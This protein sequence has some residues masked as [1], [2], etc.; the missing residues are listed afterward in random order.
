MEQSKKSGQSK[1]FD[2]LMN[3]YCLELGQFFSTWVFFMPNHIKIAPAHYNFLVNVTS[4]I[5]NNK[6]K[7][8][9][10]FIIPKT[11]I[12][13]TEYISSITPKAKTDSS[14]KTRRLQEMKKQ[15]SGEA[16]K[17]K[18]Q[19]QPTTAQENKENAKKIAKEIHADDGEH[20]TAAKE[21]DL[22]AWLAKSWILTFSPNDTQGDDNYTQGSLEI[23]DKK[24]ANK[25]ESK[26]N[27][28]TRRTQQVTSPTAPSANTT[29]AVKSAD[30]AFNEK[31]GKISATLK[32]AQDAQNKN[33]D[34]VNLAEYDKHGFSNF[35]FNA[36]AKL[37]SAQY[38]ALIG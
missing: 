33:G 4:T 26:K 5:A 13:R 25:E 34:A 36:S 15:E 12:T 20:V 1:M 31:E 14:T 3:N 23:A 10:D 6:Q 35:E 22:H 8:Y 9:L 21:N 17:A 30:K 2:P 28:Q 19:V 29:E 38:L 32:L 27:T 16:P 37:L 11:I 7:D 18:K 24:P